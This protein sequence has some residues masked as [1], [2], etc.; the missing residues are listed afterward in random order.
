[1]RVQLDGKL[2]IVTARYWRMVALLAVAVVGLILGV[3]TL[4]SFGESGSKGIPF[5]T[6]PDV[7]L[8]DAERDAQYQAASKEFDAKFDLWLRDFMVSETDPWS[9]PTNEIS[10]LFVEGQPSL[11]AATKDADVIGFGIV[12]SVEFTPYVATVRFD[13]TDAIKGN[14]G[15]VAISQSGGPYPSQDWK[16]AQLAIAPNDPL[17]R[18]GQRALLFLK[19]NSASGHHY[20][21][22]YTGHY[23]I[24]DGK[25]LALQGNPFT[26]AMDGKTEAEARNAVEQALP[27]TP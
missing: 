18:P 23:E 4:T 8:T 9:L 20:V 14:A 2:V 12:R 16:T 6:N 11:E 7:G 15:S 21:Q 3:T 24:V 1:M 26:T 19:I 27:A 22:S 25:V 17:L 10:A 13:L 5:P